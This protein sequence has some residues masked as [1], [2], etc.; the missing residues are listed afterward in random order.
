N[1]VR[2]ALAAEK[3]TPPQ[4]ALLKTA[5]ASYPEIAARGGWP[6]NI[7]ALGHRRQGAASPPDPVL[8]ARLRAA[9]AVGRAGLLTRVTQAFRPLDRH[10]DGLAAAVATFEKRQGLEPDGALDSETIAALNVP[11][12]ERIRQIEL[13]LERWRWLPRDLGP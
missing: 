9:G 4:Y 13:N 11:V 6:P 7:R 12:E 1:G 5:L 10:D 2:A 8:R 3:P